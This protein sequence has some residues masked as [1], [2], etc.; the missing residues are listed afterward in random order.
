MCYLCWKMLRHDFMTSLSQMRGC[1]V[2]MATNL[3]RDKT[4]LLF[5]TV[6]FIICSLGHNTEG[7]KPF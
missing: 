3:T 5:V 2:D 7:Y 4:I 1:G 6:L